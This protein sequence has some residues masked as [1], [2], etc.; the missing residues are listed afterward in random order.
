MTTKEIEDYINTYR[1]YPQEYT[2][3]RDKQLLKSMGAYY[4]Y[5]IK[6]NTVTRLEGRIND[7]GDFERIGLF[8]Y[9]IDNPELKVEITDDHDR[10]IA[11]F[12]TYIQNKYNTMMIE[13]N[14]DSGYNEN[15]TLRDMVSEVEY[16]RSL[17]YTPGHERNK[18][19]TE[20]PARFNKETNRLRF[21][22]RKYKDQITD[23][24]AYTTH[25]SKYDN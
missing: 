7:N 23:I 21:W 25:N 15:W 13:L 17:Y 20:D 16:L 9:P 24:K 22:I 12:G 4:R 10:S 18:L 5:D 1:A 19:K 2:G 14:H 3:K 8:R 11:L 6:N